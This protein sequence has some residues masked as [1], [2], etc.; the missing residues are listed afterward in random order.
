MEV[1]KVERVTRKARKANGQD[2]RVGTVASQVI[3]QVSVGRIVEKAE[4]PRATPRVARA[5]N[6]RQ[7]RKT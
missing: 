1:V 5:R 2:L 4:T 3:K 6:A 7:V